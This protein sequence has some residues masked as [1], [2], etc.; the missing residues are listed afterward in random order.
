MTV[1]V[2]LEGT[3]SDHTRRLAVL[4]ASTE[5]DPRDREAWKTYY[6]GLP[7][8]EARHHIMLLVREWIKEG[9]RPLV[10]STRFINKYNHE[11]EWLRGHE[12]WEHVD[13]LQ[14]QPT[15]TRIKGPDLVAQ[16]VKEFQPTVLIDDREEVRERCIGLV[17]G[18]IIGGPEDFGSESAAR[19]AQ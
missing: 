4:Q 5:A 7:N 9:I 10:Y 11:E 2:D 19:E 6:K 12:L 18:M 17:P 13:L 3:L 8:D 14:R 1:M 15:E 16:W